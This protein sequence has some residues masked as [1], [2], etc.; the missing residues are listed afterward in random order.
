MRRILVFVLLIT[1]LLTIIIGI[2]EAQ[3][4]HTGPAV[5]HIVIA[6]FFILTCIVHILINRKAVV[7]Y[8]RGK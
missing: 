4:W 3:V 8:I 5:A 2:A 1:G 6:S 7:R